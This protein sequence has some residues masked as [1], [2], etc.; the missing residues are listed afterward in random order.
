MDIY[1]VQPGD[2][3]D[4][5]AQKF[6]VTAEKLI[7]DNEL[8]EP[9]ELV[10]GQTIVITYPKQIYIAQ[11]GDT[12]SSVAS[13]Y[14]ISLTQLLKNNPELTGRNDLYSGETI[15][16][17]FDTSA[18]ITT[19]G[20]AYPYIKSETLHKTLP[21]LTYLS[22]F[23]YTVSAEGEIITIY[24][25]TEVIQTAIDYGTVP[26][27]MTSTLTPQGKPNLEVA[28]SLLINEE[29]QDHEIDQ[30]LNIMKAK[31]YYGVN[32]TFNYLSTTNQQLYENFIIKASERIQD[33]GFLYF[34][35]FN[36]NILNISNQIEFARAD[37][38][39]IGQVV[40]GLN[41]VQFIWGENYGPPVPISNIQ[42]IQEFVKY[43][44]TMVPSDKV[45]IGKPLISY[46]WELPYIPGTTRAASLTIDAALRLAYD[47]GAT[48][49]FDEVSQT[50]Y[51]LYNQINFGAPAMHVVWSIDAR[52]INALD[53]VIRE[54]NLNGAGIWTI[55]VYYPQLWLVLNSQ[56]EVIKLIPENTNAILNSNQE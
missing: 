41:F 34:A 36:P 44:I 18:Q 35:T 43:V 19:N 55:M 48:I 7:I 29:Y 38:T 45:R 24:D 47:V 54:Y 25:D 5:I 6:G 46:D 52:S 4:S 53:N 16:I 50:P 10:I 22:V 49:Q 8:G 27:M 30:I 56:F 17:S 15:V 31:G 21:G 32:M 3:I 37:Y 40:D 23:N 9:Q 12:I 28:Y 13:A 11:E 1:V 2:T 51:F 14:G 33:E 26:L 20:Y 39:K 42:N